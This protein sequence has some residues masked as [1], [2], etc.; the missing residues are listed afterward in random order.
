M[1]KY[2][3]SIFF[4]IIFLSFT[5]L[6]IKILKSINIYSNLKKQLIITNFIFSILC[7]TIFIYFIIS[8]NKL[9]YILIITSCL[10]SYDTHIFLRRSSNENKNKE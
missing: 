9:Y 8:S 4:T 3:I 6:N 10:L 7:Y 1:D 2:L 5:I